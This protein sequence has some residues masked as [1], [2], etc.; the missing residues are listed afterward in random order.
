MSK[1]NRVS[2]EPISI[3][4]DMEIKI[5]HSVVVE[6]A[7]CEPLYPCPLCFNTLRGQGVEKSPGKRKIIVVPPPTVAYV[8]C[9]RC[10][11]P[12]KVKK[13]TSPVIRARMKG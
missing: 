1:K 8:K 7:E 11:H 12:F 13:N 4:P 5:Q 3:R 6:E 2:H 10:G 9:N